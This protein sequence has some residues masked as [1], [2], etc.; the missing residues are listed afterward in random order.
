[1]DVKKTIVVI[2]AV[3]ALVFGLGANDGD[4][5]RIGVVD[6]DQAVSSTEEGKAARDEFS[7]KQRE[8]EAKMQPLIERYKE[9]EEELKA[10]QFVLS[11]D[12]LF[13]KR[14]DLEEVRNQI[15]TKQ[16]E[17]EGQLKVDH[18]RL[19]APLRA[20]LAEIVEEIGR[21]EG[22]SLILR[23]GAP[24]LMY[25]REALDVTDKVIAK[26]NQKS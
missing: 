7:R 10:K 6:L 23:R 16:K 21:E 9:K 3:A 22:F 14:L 15:V 26:F 12:A 19:V 8:A 24:G 13:Q 18:E 11:E 20:K 2:L 25:T 17:M 4:P 1:M 5:V